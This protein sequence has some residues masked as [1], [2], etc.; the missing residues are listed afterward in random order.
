MSSYFLHVAIV[1][2]AVAA[3]EC[4]VLV[5]HLAPVNNLL[6]LP[7]SVA[8]THLVAVARLLLAV[9]IASVNTL[10]ALAMPVQTASAAAASRSQLV[11]VV[12]AAL[13]AVSTA[14]ATQFHVCRLL[15]TIVVAGVQ[16]TVP[17]VVVGY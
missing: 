7:H 17:V 9:R 14:L 2:M 10:Q 16:S 1:H 3:A 6:F 12:A 8:V 5:S 15:A 4:T 11:I 13:R